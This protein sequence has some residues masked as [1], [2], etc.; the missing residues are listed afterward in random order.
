MKSKKFSDIDRIIR[1]FEQFIREIEQIPKKKR[2]KNE[3]R[4]MLLS[5]N[6]M[7]LP[8]NQEKYIT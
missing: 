8:K 5:I 7:S 2:S 1:E 4:K 6:R 3:K